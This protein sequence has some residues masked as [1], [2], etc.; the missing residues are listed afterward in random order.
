M[1]PWIVCQ[2]SRREH[3]AIPRALKRAGIASNLVT[4]YWSSGLFVSLLGKRLSQRN[5]P[6]I[7]SSEVTS[8]NLNYLLFEAWAKIRGLTSWNRNLAIG[9]WFGRNV[10]QQL[11]RLVEN[12]SESPVVFA[13]SYSASEIFPMAK[14]LGC[15]T[16]LGQIDPGI[17][18]ERI[19]IDLH[20]R[21]G[22]RPFPAAP[23]EYWDKWRRECDL[24]DIVIVNSAWSH[25]YLV[26]VGIDQSKIRIVELAYERLNPE[27]NE[28]R[29]FAEEFTRSRP[30]RILFLGQ[31]NVRKGILELVEAI[32]LLQNEP[33]EWTIVG[34]GDLD[35][36]KLFRARPNVRRVNQV[37]RHEVERYYSQADVF[38]LPTHSDGFAITLLEAASVGLPIISS[39]YCGQVVKHMENGLLLDSVSPEAICNAVRQLLADPS[40]VARMS[41]IQTKRRLRTIDDLGSE[42]T[43][44]F[45][46]SA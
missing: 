23:A 22:L 27:S 32:D 28:P 25:R 41:Q 5:H 26:K 11:P 10:T 1:S 29:Q 2:L 18:E 15:K 36:L 39:R 43:S 31:V 46:P 12:C 7:A 4:E 42:L 30:L 38:I 20:K 45:S 17:E 16:V 35:E 33:V 44:L 40:E 3:Y 21:A 8:F 9:E 13:Y 34:D 14:K 37:S 6:E 19:L 24:A